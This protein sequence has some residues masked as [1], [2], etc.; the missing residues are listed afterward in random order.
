MSV[1]EK[2]VRRGRNM[3]IKAQLVKDDDDNNNDMTTSST[4][5]TAIEA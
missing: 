2:T 4:L 5:D 1:E 3:S